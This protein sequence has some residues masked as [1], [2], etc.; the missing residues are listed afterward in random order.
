MRFHWEQACANFKKVNTDAPV[1]GFDARVESMPVLKD[2]GAMDNL[3]LWIETGVLGVDTGP[4][5]LEQVLE[6]EG[7][8]MPDT[9]S[10]AY[11]VKI[12]SDLSTCTGQV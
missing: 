10:N 1:D 6:N 4:L 9:E 12:Y 8:I 5:P 3:D 7:V 11:T 2:C